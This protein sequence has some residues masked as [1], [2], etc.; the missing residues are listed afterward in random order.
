MLHNLLPRST[1][2]PV[3]QHRARVVKLVASGLFPDQIAFV[4]KIRNRTL[5]FFYS[6]ELKIAATAPK[7]Q[8]TLQRDMFATFPPPK[9][10]VTGPNGERC[11]DDE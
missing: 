2:L 7:P 9:L 11:P 5:H 1:H 10:I 4:L 3:T 8:P 6:L